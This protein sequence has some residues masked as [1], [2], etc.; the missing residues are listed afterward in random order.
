[1]SGAS[2]WRAAAVLRWACLLMVVVSGL[3]QAALE[4]P[5]PAQVEQVIDQGEIEGQPVQVARFRSVLSA[6][7]VVR[8]LER[9]WRS[10]AGDTLV[11]T[12]TEG[13]RVLSAWSP[14]GF[15]TL[16]FRALPG[17]GSEGLLSV[18]PLTPN[19]RQA[20]DGKPS[21]AVLRMLP[22]GS[23]V[24]R[25]F[26]AVDAGRRSETIVA[27]AEGSTLWVAEAVAQQLVSDGFDRDPVLEARGAPGEARL[28]RR[29]GVEVVYTVSQAGPGRSGVVLHVTGADR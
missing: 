10:P 21:R 19:G 16:Q 17:G 1:W 14:E 7:E 4:L 5:F 3:A 29:Q 9:E 28:Y 24:H 20:A 2:R 6:N 18:W 22:A 23:T 27:T 25:R 13:W 8:A 26:A 12:R 11:E 15:R